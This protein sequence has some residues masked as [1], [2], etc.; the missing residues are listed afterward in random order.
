MWLTWRRQH[1]WSWVWDQENSGRENQGRNGAA[2][3]EAMIATVR[4]LVKSE[5]NRNFW[6]ES[7]M[8]D[9]NLTRN[10]WALFSFWVAIGMTTGTADPRSPPYSE[11]FPPPQFPHC[12]H[13]GPEGLLSPAAVVS[14]N[15]R[16][17]KQGKGNL[18]L[19]PLPSHARQS[20][21]HLLRGSTQSQSQGLQMKSR[22]IVTSG[23]YSN[24]TYNYQHTSAH[25][26]LST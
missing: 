16:G 20:G 17:R 25:L 21:S 14:E 10:W 23:S 7:D 18:L 2:N 12:P 19:K 9:S 1:G 26:C 4:T 22:C 13:Q 3:V 8:N 6:Q 15:C 11:L 5:W 24:R